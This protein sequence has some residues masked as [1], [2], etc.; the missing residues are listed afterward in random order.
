MVRALPAHQRLPS[1]QL[2]AVQAVFGLD[3]DLEFPVAQARP[4]RISS[5]FSRSIL[6]RMPES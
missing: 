3:V 1:G 2:Q 5:S 6:T 4:M